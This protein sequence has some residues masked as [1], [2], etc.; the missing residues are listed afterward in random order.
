MPSLPYSL[1]DQSHPP[2]LSHFFHCNSPCLLRRVATCIAFGFDRF[3]LLVH[4]SPPSPATVIDR[5]KADFPTKFGHSVS[6]TTRAPRA[7][8]VDGVAYHFV[9]V[10]QFQQLKAEE[11]FVETAEVHGR[12]YGTTYAAANAVLETGK[13]ALLDLDV[14]GCQSVR[15]VNFPAYLVFIS[16]P[17]MAELEKRLRLRGTETEEQIQVRL[18]TAAKEMQFKDDPIFDRLI[19]NDDLEKCYEDIKGVIEHIKPGFLTESL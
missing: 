13:L 6:H 12:F 3:L 5:L 9:T 18:H 19:I 4:L 11:K 16:P 2:T 7:G 15:R 8:E 17:S 1:A 10:E 14:Q